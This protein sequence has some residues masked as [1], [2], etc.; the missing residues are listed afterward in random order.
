MEPAAPPPP[1]PPPRRTWRSPSPTSASSPTP[2]APSPPLPIRRHRRVFLRKP[3][4]VLRDVATLEITADSLVVARHC[5]QL[6]DQQGRPNCSV[7]TNLD[8][9]LGKLATDNRHNCCRLFVKELIELDN[10]AYSEMMGG[11]A[12]AMVMSLKHKQAPDL[13]ETIMDDINGTASCCP[14]FT[15]WTLSSPW[16]WEPA[17]WLPWPPAQATLWDTEVLI[18]GRRL[19][20]G[21]DKPCEDE[22]LLCSVGKV[23]T[24]VPGGGMTTEAL[25]PVL[26]VLFITN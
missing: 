26:E 4:P 12:R 25:L 3:P 18:L 8:S 2:D 7:L 17:W 19:C 24:V 16:H 22:D 21:E 14:P 13:D 5:R 6:S 9:D 20:E 1:P 10:Q 23:D 15:S 11:L